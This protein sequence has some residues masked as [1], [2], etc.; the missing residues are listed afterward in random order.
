EA[1]TEVDN[2]LGREPLNEEH[3]VEV[4]EKIVANLSYSRDLAKRAIDYMQQKNKRIVDKRRIHKVYK[5]GELVLLKRPLLKKGKSRKLL[6]RYTGP[7]RIMKCISD[8]NFELINLK[9]PF[10]RYIA[11]ISQLKK[12]RERKETIAMDRENRAAQGPAPKNKSRKN[13]CGETAKNAKVAKSSANSQRATK[14]KKRKYIK[15]M[16]KVQPRPNITTR[17]G[18]RVKTNINYSP[19]AVSNAVRFENPTPLEESFITEIHHVNGDG[20][21][22]GV[23]Y[24]EMQSVENYDCYKSETEK[25]MKNLKTSTTNEKVKACHSNFYRPEIP[26]IVISPVLRFE[27]TCKPFVRYPSDQDGNE[28]VYVGWQGLSAV[29]EYPMTT[30]ITV[31][32]EYL[33]ETAAA[34][35]K[36]LVYI[37]VELEDCN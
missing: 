29:T 37:N 36:N 25:L 28:L 5:I 7:F 31:L 9:G 16:D 32:L 33:N 27:Q 34:K 3:R 30:A 8:I 6:M 35:Q 12:F 13:Q 17:Y 20:K 4:I 18:R 19:L 14:V 24:C 11:H 10:R 26:C 15:Y 23:V 1:R 21:D 2:I 22:R